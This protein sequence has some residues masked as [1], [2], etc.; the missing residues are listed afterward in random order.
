MDVKIQNK[1]A[2]IKDD[3]LAELKREI[4]ELQKQ[5]VDKI[6]SIKKLQQMLASQ[7]ALDLAHREAQEGLKQELEVAKEEQ[8]WLKKEM[9]AVSQ[10]LLKS[11]QENED[12][13]SQLATASERL[14][15][16]SEEHQDYVKQHDSQINH[17]KEKEQLLELQLKEINTRVT[18]TSEK[19]NMVVRERDLNQAQAEGLKKQL[20]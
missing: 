1:D 2:K 17:L 20:Q 11:K 3:K 4:A 13:N 15:T 6:E 5:K 10:V 7:E 19:Y 18:K 14:R 8:E 16:Q 9:E 12:L